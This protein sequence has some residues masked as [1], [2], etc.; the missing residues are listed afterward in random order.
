VEELVVVAPAEEV[1]VGGAVVDLEAAWE[2]AGYS[3]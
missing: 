3:R 1:A 2:V